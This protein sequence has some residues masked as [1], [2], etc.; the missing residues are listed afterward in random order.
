MTTESA[1]VGWV[2][3]RKE[4]RQL[5]PLLLLLP[6]LGLLFYF[7]GLMNRSA[8]SL[9]A[10]LAY[11]AMPFLM[12]LGTGA[13]LVG[14]EKELRTLYWLKTIPVSHSRIIGTKLTAALLSLALIWCVSFLLFWTYATTTGKLYIEQW[15]IGQGISLWDPA[16]PLNTVFILLCGIALAWRFQ[17]TFVSLVLIVPFALLPGLLSQITASAFAK[18]EKDWILIAWLILGIALAATYGWYAAK[19]CMAPSIVPAHSNKWFSLTMRDSLV[20]WERLAPQS[21]SR[22]LTWQFTAQNA[23][24][25]SLLIVALLFAACLIPFS[26]SRGLRTGEGEGFVALSAFIAS[27]AVTWLGVLA[28]HGDRLHSRIRFLADRGV[29]PNKVWRSRHAIPLGILILISVLFAV[30]VLLWGNPFTAAMQRLSVLGGIALTLAV[31][32][33]S[34]GI[35]ALSQWMGQWVQSPIVAAIVAPIFVCIVTAY[36]LM[37]IAQLEAPIPFLFIPLIVPWIATYWSMKRW[38][39]GNVGIGYWFRHGAWLGLVVVLPLLPFLLGVSRV[40][41]MP[42]DI[43]QEIASMSVSSLYAPPWS[44]PSMQD[45]PQSFVLDALDR[46]AELHMLRQRLAARPSEQDE[47]SYR[48]LF[49][50]AINFAVE[51]RKTHNLRMQSLGEAMEVLLVRELSEPDAKR[52]LAGD[53]HTNAVRFLGDTQARDRARKQALATTWLHR[54][55]AQSNAIFGGYN[56]PEQLYDQF[57]LMYVAESRLVDGRVAHL[58]QLLRAVDSSAVEQA[59]AQVRADWFAG[60]NISD[61]VTENTLEY[62][63]WGRMYPGGLWRGRWEKEASELLSV[64][65]NSKEGNSL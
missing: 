29:E 55:V 32:V 38:M 28:F 48:S 41:R 44:I 15:T 16:W 60:L 35:Y 61:A 8:S 31:V 40:P 24:A 26:R 2:L 50:G 65:N 58:W 13:L 64:L 17:S 56:L 57:W 45:Q 47:A 33:T 42:A 49:E 11:L 25:L 12:A 52:L 19:R 59:Q 62:I 1:N 54:N 4:W 63:S 43:R 10:V 23:L 18:Q 22:S 53:L 5:L 37:A 14:Q 46:W 36:Y 34:V 6:L 30:T 51:S 39:D 3:F 7:I 21:P 9:M 27:F 20:R